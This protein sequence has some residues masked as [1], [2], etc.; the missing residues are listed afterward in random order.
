MYLDGKLIWR[1][2]VEKTVGKSKEQQSVLKR[3]AGSKRGSSRSTMNATYTTYP[4]I[5]LQGTD[6][7]NTSNLEQ[8]RSEIKL[9]TTQNRGSQIDSTHI[10]ANAHYE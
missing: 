7:H 6:S 9:A 10:Y 2:H 3:L 1:N 8:I 5:R 4:I